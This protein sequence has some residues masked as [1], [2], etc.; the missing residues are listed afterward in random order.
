MEEQFIEAV[1]KVIKQVVFDFQRDPSRHM[2]ERDIHWNLF[3]CLKQQGVFQQNCVTE[4]IHA[5]FPTR[6]KYKGGEGR[7]ARGHYDLVALDPVSLNAPAVREMSPWDPWD[8]YLPLVKV[9]VAVEAKM[10]WYRRK[11]FQKIVCWDIQKLTDSQNAVGCPYFLNFVHLN[12]RGRQKTKV[13]EY[14]HGLRKYLVEQAKQHPQLR[15]LYVPSD[16]DIQPQS[17]NWI[18]TPK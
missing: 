7:S 18:S 15:I 14:Y 9:V 5:E 12:F 1:A 11:D 2:N 13:K 4:L 8:K 6:A 10:W 16:A 17:D 3:H